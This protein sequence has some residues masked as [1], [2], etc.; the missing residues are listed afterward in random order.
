MT[1]E[2]FSS[3]I[4]VLKW[5]EKISKNETSTTKPFLLLVSG[6]TIKKMTHNVREEIEYWASRKYNIKYDLLFKK[7]QERDILRKYMNTI[8]LHNLMLNP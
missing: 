2:N 3:Q 5:T 8:L 4:A 1:G 6:Y 7:E